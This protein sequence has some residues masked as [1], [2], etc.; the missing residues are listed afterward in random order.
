M[1]YLICSKLGGRDGGG[2]TQKQQPCPCFQLYIPTA[3]LEYALAIMQLQEKPI[4]CT[5]P[6]RSCA[7][8]VGSFF[9]WSGR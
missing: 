4:W 5:E 8:L 1:L 9:T 6:V 2:N 3:S 7:F